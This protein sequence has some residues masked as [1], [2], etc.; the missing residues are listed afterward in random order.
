MSDRLVVSSWWPRWVTAYSPSSPSCT[1]TCT[2]RVPSPQPSM[3]RF[4]PS[5]L[6]HGRTA[7]LWMCLHPYVLCAPLHAARACC[8]RASCTA[9]AAASLAPVQGGIACKRMSKTQSVDRYCRICAKMVPG[10]DHHC[11]WLNTCVGKRTYAIFFVLVLA[12]TARAFPLPFAFAHGRSR[13][14][15][16][17]VH[18]ALH[19]HVHGKAVC[20]HMAG[21]LHCC[22]SVCR[23]TDVPRS[24][25]TGNS[26]GHR[27][28]G[29]RA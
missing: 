5:R 6:P 19:V 20:V 22:A 4:R 2:A 26:H 17:A 3:P 9:R 8:E 11:S 1:S 16:R 25:S 13:S 10:L 28:A 14:T 7:R 24:D 27:V 18:T 12:G 23:N 15:P 21:C 29:G